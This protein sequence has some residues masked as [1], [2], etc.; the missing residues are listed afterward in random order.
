MFFY[1]GFL[2]LWVK[3]ACG[4]YSGKYLFNKSEFYLEKF[5]ILSNA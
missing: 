4:I 3:V 5:I 1:C 2:L